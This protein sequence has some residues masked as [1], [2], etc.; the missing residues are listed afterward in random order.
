MVNE[1]KI[2]LVAMLEERF[3]IFPDEV[4]NNVSFDCDFKIINFLPDI[5]VKKVIEN[6]V[7]KRDENGRYC[8]D[9]EKSDIF[10]IPYRK[11][12]EDLSFILTKKFFFVKNCLKCT[13]AK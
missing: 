5:K 9:I 2:R 12:I 7:H 13:L 1:N 3:N 11:N 6:D 8:F 4:L 10:Q